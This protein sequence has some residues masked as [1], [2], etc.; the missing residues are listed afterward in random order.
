MNYFES[1]RG[2]SINTRKLPMGEVLVI[3]FRA[4]CNNAAGGWSSG[5]VTV[6]QRERHRKRDALPF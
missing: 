5:V 2:S 6:D 4:I 1:F 3:G